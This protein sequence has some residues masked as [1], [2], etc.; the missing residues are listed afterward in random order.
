METGVSGGAP[1]LPEAPA[2]VNCVGEDTFGE[3][4]DDNPAPPAGVGLKFGDP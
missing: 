3:K 4:L 2:D 1:V